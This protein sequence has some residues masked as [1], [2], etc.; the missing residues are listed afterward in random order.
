M[1]LTLRSSHLPPRPSVPSLVKS[2][3]GGVEMDLTLASAYAILHE[4]QFDWYLKSEDEESVL[5]LVF[6]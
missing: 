2:H 3:A 5:V 1:Q 6:D 4:I